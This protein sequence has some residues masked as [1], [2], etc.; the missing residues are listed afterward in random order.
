MIE[1]HIVAFEAGQS[2]G[3]ADCTVVGAF[4]GHTDALE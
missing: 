3:L 1:R 4:A 2:P